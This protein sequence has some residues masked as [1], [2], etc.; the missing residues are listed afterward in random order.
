MKKL[1]K[2][3]TYNLRRCIH[4]KSIAELHQNNFG[5]WF[6]K[7]KDC[8]HA[9][10]TETKESTIDTWNK[11]NDEGKYFC[12]ILECSDGTL[13]CGYTNDLKKRVDVHN[14]GKGAKYTKTRLPVEMIHWESFFT[15]SQAL[16]REHVIKKMSRK[17]KLQLIDDWDEGFR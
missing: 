6:V 16:K 13:Y 8:G 10:G 14:S 7:C 2:T 12:Y 9:V 1:M 15:K 17:Q 5:G 11:M 3:E 4:C